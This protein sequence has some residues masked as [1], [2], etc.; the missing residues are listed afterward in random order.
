LLLQ[1]L[2]ILAAALVLLLPSEPASAQQL[3]L[4]QDLQARVNKAIDDGVN[5]LKLNQ[6]PWGTW[7]LNKD[8]HPMGYAAL[9]GLTL[10]VCGV[11]ADDPVIVKTAR[12][13]RAGTGACDRT[14]ELA[15]GILFLDKLIEVERAQG[16]APKKKN[17]E[18][19]KDAER[20]ETMSMRLIAGQSP[21]GGW[22]YKC[23]V[24]TGHQQELLKK[25]LRSRKELKPATLGDMKNLP[26]LQKPSRLPQIEQSQDRNKPIWG[27]TDNSNTH[28]ALLAIWAARR[29]AVP[30]EKTLKLLVRRFESSQNK[31]GSWSYDFRLGGGNPDRPAMNC[32]GLLGLAIGNGMAQD[33]ALKDAPAAMKAAATVGRPGLAVLL[34]SLDR[35]RQQV[36]M[37]DAAKKA[38][39]DKRI[40]DGFLAL[41]HFIGQPTGKW[42]NLPVPDL[43]RMWAIERVAVLYNLSLLGKKDWYRWGAEILVATQERDGNWS[44]KLYHGSTPPI[45]TCF[46]LL[47]LKRSNFASDLS[48]SLASNTDGLAKD[49][50]AQLASRGEKKEPA[51]SPP[52]SPP[53]VSTPPPAP[54]TTVAVSPVVARSKPAAPKEDF[55]PP[56]ETGSK[57]LLFVLLG[58]LMLLL[59]AGAVAAYIL[60]RPGEDDDDDEEETPA[61]KASRNGKASGVRSRSHKK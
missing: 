36:D 20:I 11:P 57:T 48:A 19:R 61:R 14:Y 40:V 10:L 58:T 18:S 60:T 7:T 9:G 2:S 35:I 43:Y 30:V 42:E 47:F 5:Y 56:P 55:S 21:T 3:A 53:V 13:V 59:I 31:D 51:P 33:A 16:L 50:E 29:H 32:V 1:G 4:P 37:R 46:A 15:L 8:E 49:I 26:V 54:T 23:P 6:N 12:F 27:L 25:A 52:S 39:N 34:V 45:D 24:L 41:D 17:S 22:T 44:S 38:E 28:F